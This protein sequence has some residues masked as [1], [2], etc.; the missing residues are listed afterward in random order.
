MLAFCSARRGFVTF[1]SAFGG[2][3]LI[4]FKAVRF[5][6]A[7]LDPGGSGCGFNSTLLPGVAEDEL[8]MIPLHGRTLPSPMAARMSMLTRAR[9]SVWQPAGEKSKFFLADRI[10]EIMTVS[11]SPASIIMVT[12]ALVRVCE[13]APGVVLTADWRV[14]SLFAVAGCCAPP[15]VDDDCAVA[16]APVASMPGCGAPES[17]GAPTGPGFLKSGLAA[18]AP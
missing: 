6:G 2:A 18:G 9:L 10:E 17:I 8:P 13:V 5:A 7:A 12:S 3:S 15:V 11:A 1:R 4:G 14:T 16:G